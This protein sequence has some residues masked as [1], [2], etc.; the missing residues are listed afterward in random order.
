M[1]RDDGLGSGW[2][3]RRAGR[4]RWSPRLMMMMRNRRT[5][6]ARMWMMMISPSTLVPVESTWCCPRCRCRRRRWPS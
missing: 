4:T 3:V 2:V 6:G 1:M 5:T